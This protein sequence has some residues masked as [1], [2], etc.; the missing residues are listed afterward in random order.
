MA[1]GWVK[2]SKGQSRYFYSGSGIMATGWVK[3]G[4]GQSRYFDTSTGIMKTGWQTICKKQYYF[5]TSG[6]M[7]TGWVK[8]SG[9]SYY[10]DADTGVLAVST[11]VDSDHYVGSNGAYIPGYS[12]QDF[13]WPLDSQWKTLSSYF[14]NRSSPG[15]IGSTNH[16][17][18]DIPATTNTPVYAIEDGTV[19]G[20]QTEAQS[21]GAGN[22]LMINHGKGIISEYMHLNKFVSTIKVGDSV[23]K[24]QVIGYVGSTGNSTG[25]HLHLGII[26]NG[27]RRDPLN[28][29][30]IPDSE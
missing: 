5:D 10:F 13:I 16:K 4:K 22:Y 15:G 25:P 11:W 17:G 12:S 9:E 8:L 23:K 1:L 18:I 27:T 29:V 24:G 26:V 21:G 30:T 2:N 14:G 3:N 7:K 19:V 20:K 6:I 28:Y